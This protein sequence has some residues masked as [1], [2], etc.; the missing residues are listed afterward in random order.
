MFFIYRLATIFFFP[1]FVILILFR[2]LLKKEDSKRFKEKIFKSISKNFK[3][4]YENLVWF[5]GASIVEILSFK[6]LIKKFIREK[7]T[8]ILITSVTTS[9]AE[10]IKKDFK[11]NKKIKHLYFPLDVPH[12]VDNFLKTFKP[13]LAVFIDSEI[14]P[15]FI[16]EI[17]KKKIPLALINA[18]ITDKTFNKWNIFKKFSKNIFSSF[19]ICLASS[20]NS[21]NNLKKLNSNNTKYIGNLKFIKN[22]TKKI[23]LSNYTKLHFDKNKVW[24]AVSTHVPEE[25]FCMET[26]KLMKK[27]YSRLITIIIPR[28]IN[29][30]KSIYLEAKKLNLNSQIL[31][32]K[33]VI[34]KRAEILIINS[35]GTVTKY[36][37]YCKSVF[38]GKSMLKKLLLVGGQNPIEAAYA[39]CFIY[40][41]P[42]VYNF[43]EVYDYLD[44]NKISKKIHSSKELAFNLIKDF[45]KTNKF[46]KDNIYRLNKYGNKILRKTFKELKS[47]IL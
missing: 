23:K 40:H 30:A 2:I 27:K 45:E 11:K 32:E 7:N 4:D 19:D 38:L 22:E 36:M 47:F 25:K 18:R 33:S 14:W 42:Y 39:G 31:N 5:H 17:K 28:H 21:K 29:R 46:N 34:N 41:G 3:R 35:Y 24:C 44:K 12:L 13:N 43:R 6:P 15:N 9:S 37:K 26:H 20:L 8:K 16:Y 10:I 1:L